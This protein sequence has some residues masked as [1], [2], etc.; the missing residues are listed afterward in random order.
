MHELKYTHS[1]TYETSY[2]CIHNSMHT[3]FDKVIAWACKHQAT[4][5][6]E[7]R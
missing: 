2:V 3:C 4:V 1:N 6:V 5:H 7:Q